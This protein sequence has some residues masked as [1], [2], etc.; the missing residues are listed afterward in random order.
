MKDILKRAAFIVFLC[1]L[2]SAFA[3]YFVNVYAFG[4]SFAMWGIALSRVFIDLTEELH[5]GVK[6]VHLGHLSGR[7]FAY[8]G[9][10]V[11]A[12]EDDEHCYWVPAD[13]VR[14]ITGQGAN[15]RALATTY[16]GG[17]EVFGKPPQGHLRDDAL[18]LYLAK[19]QDLRGIKFKNWVERNIA[20]P[21]RRRREQLGV[22]LE[23]P[24]KKKVDEDD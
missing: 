16:P 23:D 14:Q 19:E 22:R 20:F 1:S 11:N 13:T 3:Y 21:A 4:L 6:R 5:Y 10:T 8:L 2:F 17:W 7:H 12:F 15:D 18:L 9:V 24:L